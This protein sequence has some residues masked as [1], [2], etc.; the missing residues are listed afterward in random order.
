M[1]KDISKLSLKELTLYRRYDVGF[2]F[3]FY[4]LMP[5]TNSI[6]KCGNCKGD[7]EIQTCPMDILEQVGLKERANNLP[8][9]LSVENNNESPL[10]E[11]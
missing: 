2:V 5:Q 7:Y 1:V 3:Q 10:R 6:G 4:N 11:L 9:Q 8:S